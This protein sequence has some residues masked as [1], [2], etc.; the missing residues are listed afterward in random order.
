MSQALPQALAGTL[1]DRCGLTQFPL[2]ISSKAR[3]PWADEAWVSP[4]EDANTFLGDPGP[5]VKDLL[6]SC[7]TTSGLSL[8]TVAFV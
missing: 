2:Q 6:A 5:G 1:L 3:A 4:W 7:G 8:D